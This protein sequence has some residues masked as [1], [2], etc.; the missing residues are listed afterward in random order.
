M[1]NDNSEN[2]TNNTDECPECGSNETESGDTHEHCSNCGIPRETLELDPGFIPTNP[3]AAVD[4]GGGLGGV[5][6]PT[7]HHLYRRLDRLHR[8]AT[9]DEPG[10]VD[11]IIGELRNSALGRATFAAACTIIETAD[12]KETLGRKRHKMRGNP[13][14][15]KDDNRQYR[16]RIYAAAAL[17]LLFQYR[18][19]ENRVH[20]LIGEWNLDKNDLIKAKKMLW[21]LVRSELSWLTNADDDD[22]RARANNIDLRLTVYR[23]H[24]VALENRATA[25]AIYETAVE[26]VR[27]M[28]EP[29]SGGDVQHHGAITEWPEGAVAGRAFF[30]AMIQHGLPRECVRELHATVHFYNLDSYVDR[31]GAQNR[32]E[33]VEEEA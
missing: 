5:M 10:F 9:H 31:L 15:S 26:I 25:F 32:G 20:S 3:N 30:E 13:G 19:Q 16:Q 24:L 17:G 28:G 23:D 8:R 1:T 4:A 2:K 6:G 33:D 14:T 22:V 11:G 18:R 7:N 29:V 27:Q 12:S 21:T